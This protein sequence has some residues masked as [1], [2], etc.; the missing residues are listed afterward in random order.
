MNRSPNSHRLTLEKGSPYLKLL[1]L[2]AVWKP[3]GTLL[4]AGTSTDAN[5]KMFL[6]KML[7][8]SNIYLQA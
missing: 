7:Q 6:K 2:T 3:D 1:V 5:G 4:S 8:P